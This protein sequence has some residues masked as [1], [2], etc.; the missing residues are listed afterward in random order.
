MEFAGNDDEWR[1]R[2][3]LGVDALNHCNPFPIAL[4][5]YLR[6]S[7]PLSACNDHT[8]GDNTDHEACLV[9][10]IDILILD[11]IFRLLIYE[12]RE[13]ARD[14]F[15]VFVEGPLIIVYTRKTRP[16]L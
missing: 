4:L 14:L 8:R 10:V 6:P 2:P 15:K 5:G 9:E 11:T 16:E 3:A 1:D 7:T 12:K 13:L